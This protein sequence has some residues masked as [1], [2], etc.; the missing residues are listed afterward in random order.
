MPTPD[1]PRA[2]TTKPRVAKKAVRKKK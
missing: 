2:K 1:M